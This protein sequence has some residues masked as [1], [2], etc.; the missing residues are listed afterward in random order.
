[1]A[2]FKNFVIIGGGGGNEIQNKLM[3]FDASNPGDIGANSLRKMICEEST[4]KDVANFI[5]MAHVSTFYYPFLEL[6][7]F[8]CVHGAIYSSL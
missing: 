4:G 3:V 5:D 7:C 8:G 6:K 2:T 1:M